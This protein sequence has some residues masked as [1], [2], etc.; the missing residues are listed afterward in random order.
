MTQPNV[1]PIIPHEAVSQV[2]G[3]PTWPPFMNRRHIGVPVD[4]R[5]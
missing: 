3:F 1:L 5:P 2:P 4:V